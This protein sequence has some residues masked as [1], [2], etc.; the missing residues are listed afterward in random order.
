MFGPFRN[1]PLS[2]FSDPQ[3]KAAMENALGHIEAEAKSAR[4]HPLIIGGKPLKTAE[5]FQ[6]FNPSNPQQALGAFAKAGAADARLAIAAAEKAFPA[7]AAEPMQKR[8]EILRRAAEL[9]RKYKFELSAVMTLEGG[10]NWVEADADTAEAID[11]CEYYARDALNWAAGMAVSY[12]PGER[13]ETFYAPLGVISVIP[14][15]NFPCA[16]LTGMTVA[17]L[18]TGNT[19]CLK[20]SSETPLIGWKVAQILFEAGVPAGVLNFVPGPGATC[21]EELV[22][23]PRVRAICFT[24]SKEVGLGIVEKAAK[25]QPGQKWIKRVVAEM[26][27]KDTL[28]VDET[29]D[30]D[31]AAMAAVTSAFGYQG[32]KCSACSRVVIVEDVYEKFVEKLLTHAGNITVGPVVDPGNYMGPV[33]NAASLKKVLEYV[34]IGRKTAKVIHGGA[35]LEL[36]GGYFVEPTIVDRVKPGSP[37]DQEEIFGPVLSLLRARDF[38][39]ALALANATEFGLTGGLISTSR[40]RIERA[41]REFFV[42]NLYVNR[43]I[44][45]ALVGVQPF[46]GFNMSGTDSK[47]GGADYL[48][49][50]L[51]A[52]SYTERF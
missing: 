26:G 37:L 16:I 30:L 6:T 21:G 12:Y 38:D 11:F 45:G 13:N 51:Q 46:G 5:T 22:V 34:A 10:K 25:H 40:E 44:T 15:W 23:N 50:F 52:K 32:Q 33:I 31:K 2:D 27:G 47:A 1:E 8:A 43:K 20:P 39:H 9:M 14:P 24:G 49:L 3:N 35:K 42:G 17:A 29:A 48:G 28:I 4:P 7:W 36:D 41:R 18:V 19:V